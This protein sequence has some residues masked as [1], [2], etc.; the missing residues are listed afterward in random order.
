[1]KFINTHSHVYLSEFDKDR[2]DVIER[3]RLEGVEKILLPDIDAA[4]RSKIKKTLTDF[5]DICVPMLGIHPTSVTETFEAELIDF[6][7]HLQNDTPC[8]IGEIGLDLYW[9]TTFLEEQKIVC[10]HQIRAAQKH[11]KPIVIHVRNAFDEIFELLE[12]LQIPQ[13]SG[14]FHCFSGT[15][16]QAQKAIDM[17]FYLGIGGVVTFKNAGLDTVVRT[18]DL[19]KIVLETDDP[20]LTPAPYRGK[21]NEPSYVRYVANKLAEIF[22]CSVE[23]VARIT[24]A[25]A[26]KLFSV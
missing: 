13:F 19:D 12:T 2:Y 4:H 11:N 18:L 6:D 3:A 15:A 24:T 16:E 20:W 14:V 9:D 22:S 21:R 5:P 23:D 17:G 7:A 10:V 25:N 1:M 8:A 26:Q